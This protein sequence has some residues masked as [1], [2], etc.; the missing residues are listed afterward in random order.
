[1]HPP[2]QYHS[3]QIVRQQ[4]RCYHL[5]LHSTRCHPFYVTAPKIWGAWEGSCAY[6][7][8]AP[9][10]E[11][12][13]PQ[14]WGLLQPDRAAQH[15]LPSILHG[16]AQVSV[17]N[18]QKP[19][20]HTRAKTALHITPA[21]AA[22]ACSTHPPPTP[23]D[24]SQPM[25]GIDDF[26]DDDDDESPSHA[27]DAEPTEPTERPPTTGYRRT[28]Q[29]PAG[30]HERVQRAHHPAARSSR[31]AGAVRKAAAL[32]RRPLR[33]SRRASSRRFVISWTTPST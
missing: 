32:Q 27:M 4:P 17:G 23:S 11:P 7:H 2:E 9:S 16:C 15:S 13:R 30:D 3:W 10:S 31:S 28:N 1:M 8:P 26:F 18:Q 25:P 14:A 19:T 29:E 5:G 21:R 24:A 22:A 12:A 33:I 6:Q 20:G